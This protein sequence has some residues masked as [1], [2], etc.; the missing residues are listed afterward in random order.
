MIHMKLSFLLIFT[1]L[2][3]SCGQHNTKV[4]S[5]CDTE[6]DLSYM[7]VE[8]IYDRWQLEEYHPA[9]TSSMK[10]IHVKSD[11]KYRLQF[12][13]SGSFSCTTDCNT[14][15]GNFVADDSLLSFQNIAW[16][17]MACEDMSIENEMKALLPRVQ[18]Y[19]VTSDSLFLKNDEGRI[20]A[21]YSQMVDK[22]ISLDERYE[23]K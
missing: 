16:T 14:L 15:S 22:S 20:L 3:A 18:R 21:V 8:S 12:L 23:R 6:H 13:D 2:M 7:T 4:S 11:K 5:G 19:T 10:L 1:L 17:E 9:E